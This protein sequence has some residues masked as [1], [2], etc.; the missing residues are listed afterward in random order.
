VVYESNFRT[1]KTSSC[2]K[3]GKGGS[4][5]VYSSVGEGDHVS[6]EDYLFLW[7]RN[8]LF[9]LAESQLQSEVYFIFFV[10]GAA[11]VTSCVSVGDRLPLFW[12]L[13]ITL[14]SLTTL[15]FMSKCRTNFFFFMAWYRCD[16]KSIPHPET[17]K[18]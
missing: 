8:E 18:A 15:P 3:G 10:V 9:Y 6:G 13:D 14:K 4:T 5:S 2:K 11:S 7:E 1:D 17:D 12:E 16:G